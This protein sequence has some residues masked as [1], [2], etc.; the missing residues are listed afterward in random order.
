MSH[1]IIEIKARCDRHDEIRRILK[2]RDADF[3]GLDRQ[4]DTYFNVPDGR[5]KLRIGSIEQN[6]IHYKRPNQA[7]PKQSNVLLYKP[8]V[9]EDLKQVLTESL[10][11]L[12]EVVKLREIYFVGNVKIHLDKV[13]GLGDFVEIEAIDDEDGSLGLETISR[14][15]DEFMKLF[16][17]EENELVEVSY[18]DMLLAI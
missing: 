18:S 10:G 6:L 5:L 1:R 15:C 16:S 14:Q 3:V 9:G 12:V 8:N 4:T 7:G 13:D 17:I 11:V 2:D